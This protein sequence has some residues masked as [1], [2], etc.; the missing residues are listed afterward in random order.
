MKRDVVDYSVVSSRKFLGVGQLA[1]RT[2]DRTSSSVRL[3]YTS[4]AARGHFRAGTCMDNSQWSTVVAA[5]TD[6]EPFFS[7]T[8]GYG[9]REAVVASPI[10]LS[11]LGEKAR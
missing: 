9:G 3:A 6:D 10:H 2:C 7:R 5:M 1:D 4:S 8:C 11:R